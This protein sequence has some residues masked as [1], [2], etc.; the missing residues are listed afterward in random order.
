[1]VV[2][3][4][5]FL[6]LIAGV[7]FTCTL[8]GLQAQAD[9]CDILEAHLAKDT[10][11]FSGVFSLCQ[12]GSSPNQIL[13]Q[14][15]E[16]FQT[17]QA[18][19]ET[20]SN[21]G[22]HTIKQ[23]Y[24]VIWDSVLVQTARLGLDTLFA[25]EDLSWAYINLGYYYEAI[26]RDYPRAIFQ[27]TQAHRI[28]SHSSLDL[29]DSATMEPVWNYMYY[30]LARLYLEIRDYDAALAYT[31]YHPIYGDPQIYPIG[32]SL[33]AHIM[34][35]VG[36]SYMGLED[37]EEALHW[38][39][40]AYEMNLSPYSLEKHRFDVS[41][42]NAYRKLKKYSKSTFHFRRALTHLKAAQPRLPDTE[43]REDRDRIMANIYLFMGYQARSNDDFEL[44]QRYYETGISILSSIPHAD[45]TT[46]LT[47]FFIALGN[48]YGF[49]E[50][51][52]PDTLQKSLVSEQSRSSTANH[53]QIAATEALARQF[54]L[55]YANRH[56]TQH[57]E[58]A[59]S[60]YLKIRD[61]E[62]EILANQP[63]ER[64]RM[65]FM[66]E[67]Q[68]RA[69]KAL[70]ITY[71]LWE[72][73]QGPDY[74]NTALQLMDQSRANAIATRMK[75]MHM[76]RHVPVLDSLAQRLAYLPSPWE[77]GTTPSQAAEY[78]EVYHQI[79][80]QYPGYFRH[81]TERS[82]LRNEQVQEKLTKEEALVMFMC[83]DT[84]IYRLALNSRSIHF[85]QIHVDSTFWQRL[86]LVKTF[87]R[88]PHPKPSNQLAFQEHA[89]YLYEKLLGDI[90]P[91]SL[92]RWVVVS[93][94]P[95]SEVPIDILLTDPAPQAEVQDF[96]NLKY[97]LASYS[98]QYSSS[99][100]EWMR[101]SPPSIE[102]PY[103]Y[104][105]FAPTFTLSNSTIIPAVRTPEMELFHN[106]SEIL[107]VKDVWGNRDDQQFFLAENAQK[108]HFLKTAPR[109]EMV[110]LAMHAV[111]ME[112]QPDS[113]YL[114]FS[115]SDTTEKLFQKDLYRMRLPTKLVILSACHTGVGP[116]VSGEGMKSLGW[117][118]N[119]A[120]CQNVLSSL[121]AADDKAS[122]EIIPA[123]L[124]RLENHHKADALRKA[125]LAYVK[126]T[127]K[128]HAQRSPYYWAGTQLTGNHEP[129]IL[130]TPIN[131]EK[132]PPIG[133]WI[134]IIA[135]IYFITLIWLMATQSR[136]A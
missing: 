81:I 11:Y 97:A 103:R 30:P 73:T 19:E 80:A 120:G 104:S 96:G 34:N 14:V 2:R 33:K 71:Q 37:Y 56:D 5:T 57:L 85:D 86:T 46:D 92:K 36:E 119:L 13:S 75:S 78:L 12:A 24:T 59:L 131:P 10:S 3:K 100:S 109:S 68:I 101:D 67:C 27:Y 114:L 116:N 95:L 40:S 21:P 88:T 125:K 82:D 134:R 7:I 17:I 31:Q 124:A 122:S 111:M 102:Y 117:A 63:F 18:R 23:E 4:R 53:G 15:I 87:C 50:Q 72:T 69:K 20:D 110:H 48:L 77:Q 113:S 106:S 115:S 93:D 107:A 132:H 45:V 6:Q 52:I 54:L 127:Q 32:D 1:M 136:S 35:L 105:G 89:N 39:F 41:I 51:Y 44:A 43:F 130:E 99:V 121:W 62:E 74:L 65:Q 38:Y 70:K 118:V 83:A 135:G 60:C 108:S 84:L 64:S 133:R 8:Y 61:L 94:Y 112:Q 9:F 76:R 58:S 123:Y 26:N 47:P 126:N 55:R 90:T 79:H 29:A 128:T 42:G 49:M 16:G 129:Y 25:A 22:L 28:L 91:D 66:E 98:F